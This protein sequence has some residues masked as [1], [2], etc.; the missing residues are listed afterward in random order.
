MGVAPSSGYVKEEK[1]GRKHRP[2]KDRRAFLRTTTGV[3]L[4]II[5]TDEREGVR[6]EFTRRVVRT[7]E[8]M[9]ER[10]RRRREKAEKSRE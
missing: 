8:G 6:G 9:V 1:E 10:R 2:C 5:C 7:N 3:R 4:L